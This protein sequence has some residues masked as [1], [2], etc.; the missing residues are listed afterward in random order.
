MADISDP[1]DALQGIAVVIP[2]Y[3]ACDHIIGVIGALEPLVCALKPPQFQL[4]LILLVQATKILV[5]A[6]Y[7]RNL[8]MKTCNRML[9]LKR[10]N[11]IMDG[12][13][14]EVCQANFGL[15]VCV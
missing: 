14:N 10:D 11:I 1:T 7:S 15:G 13:P 5:T 2:T 6:H 4:F 9:W 3:K 12:A 8:T